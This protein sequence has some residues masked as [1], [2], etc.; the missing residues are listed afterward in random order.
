MVFVSTAAVADPLPPTINANP[1]SQSVLAGVN[2]SFTVSASGQ[3]SLLYQWTFNGTNLD[4]DSH[5][6]GATSSNLVVTS[7]ST[8]DAG[9]YQVIITNDYGSV[10]SAIVTLTVYDRI[11]ITS[12]PA[13][14]GVL[15]GDNATFTVIAAGTT[16]AYRWSFNGTPLSDNAR[17]SG[18]STPNLVISNVQSSDV[19]RYVVK[20]NNLLSTA[21]S[22][23]A[24]L[25]PQA[26]AGGPVTALRF[27][28]N[29]NSLS[30]PFSAGAVPTN[31]ITVEFWQRLFTGG[32]VLTMTLTPETSG[33]TFHV[34]TPQ[35]DGKIYWA[36]GNT[37]TGQLSYSPPS[38][39][40]GSW[41]HFAM[42]VSQ[43]SNFMAIY[44]NGI[45]EAQ[46][47]GMVP[48]LPGNNRNLTFGINGIGQEY[49]E[50]RV[51]NVARS[52][53]QIR[54]NMSRSLVGNEPGLAAY[55]RFDEGSGTNAYDSSGHGFTGL[56]AHPTWGNSTAPVVLPGASTLSVNGVM[57][58]RVSLSGTAMS[59]GA[60]T[61][62]WFNYGATTNYGNTT[63]PVSIDGTN[64]AAVFITNALAGMSPGTLYHYQ[65]M[66]TNRA[67]TN[68]GLDIT[69]STFLP[70]TA[71]ITPTTAWLE[72]TVRPPFGENIGLWF[73]YG[74]TTNYGT[75]TSLRLING[76]NSYEGGA[77]LTQIYTV[78]G[79]SPGTIYHYQIG[80]TNSTGTNYGADMVFTTLSNNIATLA[81]L[82]G[83]TGVGP[84]NPSFSAGTISYGAAISN[85]F[86][87]INLTPVATDSNAT[88]QVSINGGAFSPVAFGSSSDPLPVGIGQNVITILV[89]AQNKVATQNY[90]LNAYVDTNSIVVTTTAPSGP[91]SLVSAL[92]QANI[93]GSPHLITL[94]T[95]GSYVFS[96]ADNFW[97]GPNALPAVAADISIEGNGASL[98]IV[99]TN[100]L[101]FF[102]VG[103]DPARPATTNYVTPGAGQLTLRHLTLKGGLSSGGTGGGGGAGMGGA[104]FNQGTLLLDSVTLCNNTAK[105]GSGGGYGFNSTG[106]S[107]GG[108]GGNGFG[109]GIFPV[110][111]S[112]GA[113]GGGT[114]GAGGGGGGFL[115]S[116]NGVT[117]NGGGVPDGLAAPGGVSFW[118][119]ASAGGGGASGHGSG[120]GGGGL[121][122]SNGGGGSFGVNGAAGYSFGGG[123]GG[124]GVGGGGG[125]GQYSPSGYYGSNGF[126]A[127]G[128]G[129]FGGGGG[130]GSAVWMLPIYSGQNIVGY[131]TGGGAAGN[132]GF[133]GGAGGYANPSGALG[134][135]GGGNGS[136]NL[137]DG[138]AGGAGMGGAVFNHGG[139]L[140]LVNS[141][142]ANNNAVG[143]SGGS[144]YFNN[145]GAGMGGAI[146]NLNG[147]VNLTNT[148]LAANSTSG[149]FGNGGGAL[150]NLAYDSSTAQNATVIL[151]NSILGENTGG[152][153]V[154][155]DQPLATSA[156]TNV[157]GASLTA[158]EPNIIQ[159]F[160]NTGGI[161]DTSGVIIT[162]PML[163]PLANNGGPTPTMALLPGSPAAGSGDVALATATDQQGAPRLTGP[164]LNLGA[165]QFQAGS[166]P[167]LL[168][169]CT[170]P[171]PSKVQL[172]FAGNTGAG[173]TILSAT[174]LTLPLA[175][176]MVVGRATQISI[177][178]F[179][180][181]DSTATNQASRYYRVRQP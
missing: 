164:Q 178:I 49:D 131:V 158:T 108:L 103:A 61:I 55:W 155:N 38:S 19:G 84:L 138:G 100:C 20:V 111:S 130:D 112:G 21:S 153:D 114:F 180:F 105:G 23:P 121:G 177:G 51:W 110:G 85:G 169:A 68:T 75:N 172:Q 115:V 179:Q 92:N 8:S 94:A 15:L 133:G 126:G 45:L 25:A 156:G 59:S 2:A 147:T 30:I 77:S 35:S 166:A 140:T 144:L 161:C 96:N 136:G 90:V 46:K 109:G 159:Q 60:D 66:A 73:R 119:G 33:G 26:A 167:A 79:L 65:L 80:V 129:G 146:F 74:T 16:P 173:Y 5:I 69:F 11:Q 76:I 170:F 132:G 56:V 99:N 98:Q 13:S 58:T 18:S 70:F 134:G 141:T 145:S 157:S 160:I 40:F 43:S 139:I 165:V 97:Y 135:F 120:G 123:G 44:R 118:G 101:R 29:N 24:F 148:T 27:T 127:G 57:D 93:F 149:A 122:S 143:G 9:P 87:A 7:V 71:N 150:Y 32:S 128:G 63:T 6:S 104:I 175:D 88:I 78:G 53:D 162:N 154:V 163:G 10:T 113:G 152:M 72:C 3:G 142:L 95:N 14:E 91:G 31:E 28:N 17:I 124:G 64:Y 22:Q 181:T 176:W 41:Q 107:G 117:G 48:L 12:Q 89:K 125:G 67:G 50:V 116:E 174:N 171:N 37:S 151:V 1:V 4:N 102:Y 86:S 34:Y 47:T 106:P 42:V 137:A 36:V 62:C 54:T 81:S 39:L 83:G 168:T 52:A 82:S